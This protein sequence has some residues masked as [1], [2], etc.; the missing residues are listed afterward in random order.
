M[1]GLKWGGK[2][3]ASPPC[4]GPG[5]C[6]AGGGF[7]CG[8][9]IVE[10]DERRQGGGR[11]AAAAAA[12]VSGG[13][14]R[15]PRLH[16]QPAR[17]PGE[18]LQPRLRAHDFLLGPTLSWPRCLPL[19][20]GLLPFLGIAIPGGPSPFSESAIPPARPPAF[21]NNEGGSFLCRRGKSLSL[22]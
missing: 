1:A 15:G 14:R 7:V 22:E 16:G 8:G 12:F 18:P 9:C 6:G 5:R 11:G 10:R 13:E 20:A 17:G 19:P 21:G 2:R 4:R 3:P